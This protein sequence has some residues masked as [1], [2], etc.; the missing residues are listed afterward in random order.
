MTVWVLR[1]GLHR[2]VVL[3]GLLLLRAC[4]VTDVFVVAYRWAKSSTPLLGTY[5]KLTVLQNDPRLQPF[6]S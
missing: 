4:S 3:G 1:G 6:R 2:L 5:T